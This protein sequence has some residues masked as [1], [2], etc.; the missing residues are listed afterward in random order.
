MSRPLEKKL[1]I[2]TGASRGESHHLTFIALG[3]AR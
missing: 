2:V 1:G 3:F